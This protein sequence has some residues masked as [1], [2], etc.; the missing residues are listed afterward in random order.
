VYIMFVNTSINL[1]IYVHA[2]NYRYTYTYICTYIH[3]FP[4]LCRENVGYAS[5][6][7]S[8]GQ[9]FGFFLA[10]QGITLT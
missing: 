5:V 6:C 3:I 7:N 4:I 1:F 8:I 10:N 9:S 2:Y